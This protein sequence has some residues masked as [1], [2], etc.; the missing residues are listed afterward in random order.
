M[1]F[2]L[3]AH[4]DTVVGPFTRCIF[5]GSD[6]A[7]R[8]LTDEHAMPAA[9]G[10][11]LVLESATCSVC[12]EITS[13]IESRCINSMFKPLRQNY[14]YKSARGRLKEMRL[15]VTLEGPDGESKVNLDREG[16]PSFV[17]LPV[18]HLPTLFTGEFA[19]EKFVYRDRKFLAAANFPENVH[20]LREAH[21]GS[22]IRLEIKVPE[23]DFGRLLAK[24]AHCWGVAALGADGFSPTLR[25]AILT[26]D[27]RSLS[28]Y[29]GT[30][31]WPQ[32]PP[33][34]SE[35]GSRFT[36]RSC[37]YAHVDGRLLALNMESFA[38]VHLA[39]VYVCLFGWYNTKTRSRLQ[40]ESAARTGT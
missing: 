12:Q 35:Y 40:R 17:G 15:P 22:K 39:P 4:K 13:G 16:Y 38:G 3:F 18:Y 9:L 33:D 21:E 6:G 29:V 1:P 37:G 26:G 10:G 14:R 25:D 27:Q 5:C 34:F 28:R 32:Q 2:E 19:R 30:V 8:P 20:N 11:R 24:V 36:I 7:G 31:E 23:V